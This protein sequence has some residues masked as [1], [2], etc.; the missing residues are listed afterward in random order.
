M[1]GVKSNFHRKRLL[2]YFG[3]IDFISAKTNFYCKEIYW[4]EDDVYTENSMN[5][6]RY[7]FG[8]EG[9][10]HTICA[11]SFKKVEDDFDFDGP[12]EF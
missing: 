5:V 4:D 10:E 2:L 8:S 3:G 6:I 7:R 1:M 11:C 9:Q 12:I